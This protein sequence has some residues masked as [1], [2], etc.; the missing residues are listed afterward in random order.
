MSPED[1][2]REMHKANCF[3]MP[4]RGETFGLV[5]VEALSQK[6]PII[7]AHN[8]GFDEFY[9]D[10]FVGYPAYAG[11]VNSIQKA[12]E[13]VIQNYDIIAKNIETLDLDKDFDWNNISEKYI[14]IYKSNI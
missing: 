8:E 3:I 14:S 9:Q 2:I 7:Y 11:N 5:Y 13:D 12:I 10:G 4:S 1:L 6:L